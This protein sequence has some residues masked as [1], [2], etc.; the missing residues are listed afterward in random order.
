MRSVHLPHQASAHP[1]CPFPTTPGQA[2]PGTRMSCRLRESAMGSQASSVLPAPGQTDLPRPCSH[3]QLCLWPWLTHQW[4][5]L[6]YFPP[7]GWP[8]KATCSR[9]SEAQLQPTGRGLGRASS[10]VKTDSCLC[11]CLSHPFSWV[12]GTEWVVDRKMRPESGTF[13]NTGDGGGS[14]LCAGPARNWGV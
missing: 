14:C 7:G 1:Q 13:Q 5:K 11:L 12:E 8:N 2:H 4:E 10:P 9:Q 3:V 6:S